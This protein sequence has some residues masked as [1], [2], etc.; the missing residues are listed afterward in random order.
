M[1]V[2]HCATDLATATLLRGSDLSYSSSWYSRWPARVTGTSCRFADARASRSLRDPS[3]WSRARKHGLVPCASSSRPSFTV[4]AARQAAQLSA[5]CRAGTHQL[6]QDTAQARHSRV[7]FPIWSESTPDG[8]V[9]RRVRLMRQGAGEMSATDTWMNLV[10]RDARWLKS[11][12][13]PRRTV[14]QTANTV[15]VTLE[16]HAVW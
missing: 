16:R 3:A 6:R 13:S 1:S 12:S 4:L 10:K 9:A 7:N 15:G 2:W 14:H 8:S 5:T 11:P